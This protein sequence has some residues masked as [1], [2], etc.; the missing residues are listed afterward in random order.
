MSVVTYT[1]SYSRRSLQRRSR[2]RL[3]Y[4]L[5][6]VFGQRLAPADLTALRLGP[7]GAIV[8]RLMAVYD[9]LP[10]RTS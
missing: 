7:K 1:C 10:E 4:E 5:V 2:E 3:M 8:D 6:Y 9:A